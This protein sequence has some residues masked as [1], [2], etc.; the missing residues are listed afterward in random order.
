MHPSDKLCRPIITAII[1]K[2]IDGI[3]HIL[4]QTRWKPKE[5]PVYSGTL[6]LPA[7]HIYAFEDVHEAV[8]REVFEETGLHVNIIE[9][10]TRTQIFSPRN[11]ATFGFKVFCAQQQIKN[12]LPWIGFTFICE[13]KDG[14]FTEQ[15]SE[16]RDQKW[17]PE[18]ELEKI[19]LNTPEKIFTFHLPPLAFY[20][21]EK[22]ANY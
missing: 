11:D 5:D 7:G 8:R 17:I 20:F 9:P 6:E 1:R 10:S 18:Q 4:M 16:T 15:K 19:I 12:G 13:T 14:K 22:Q 3:P 21:Q 2:N